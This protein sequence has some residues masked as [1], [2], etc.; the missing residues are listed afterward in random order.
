MAALRSGGIAN[1]TTP[2]T[3]TALIENS[4]GASRVCFGSHPEKLA[5]SITS[6][7]FPEQTTYELTLREICVGPKHKVAALQPAARE[8]EPR[9]R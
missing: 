8:Q 6:L 7:L 1:D 9:G 4:D 2:V 3:G 5:L